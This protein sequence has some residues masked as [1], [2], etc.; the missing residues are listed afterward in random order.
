MVVSTHP[1]L[2]ELMDALTRLPDLHPG[3]DKSGW[4]RAFWL[5]QP[6]GRLSL[7]ALAL[8][9]ARPHEVKNDPERFAVLSNDGRT[10]AAVFPGDAQAVIDLA[11]EDAD[12]LSPGVALA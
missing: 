4:E 11:N 3:H 8:R 12:Q 7:Q 2:K 9:A 10:P 6:R 5:Y 1:R